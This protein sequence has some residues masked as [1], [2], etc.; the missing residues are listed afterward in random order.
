[1]KKTSGDS[2]YVAFLRAVNVAGHG[3]VRME[4]V[5]KAFAAAGCREVKS[6]IQSGN[7]LFRARESRLPGLARRIHGELHDLIGEE[8]TV[9]FRRLRDLR[10][11]IAENPFRRFDDDPE[12]K[13]YVTFLATK[14]G[15][16][17]PFPLR[18]TKEA[19]RAISMKNLEVF[20]VSRRK[21]NGFYGFPNNFIEDRLGVRATSRN[22]STLRKMIRKFDPDRP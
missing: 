19:L 13:L 10:R 6:Y 9:M 15:K 7:I 11:L 22:W 16:R 17:V 18:S 3:T 1:M 14:P 21:K 5:R 8:P 2:E 20:V 4:D 12:I